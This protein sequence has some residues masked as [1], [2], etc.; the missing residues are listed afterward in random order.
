MSQVLHPRQISV[1]KIQI[2]S[3]RSFK[4]E[5]L[6]IVWHLVF[7]YLVLPYNVSLIRLLYPLYLGVSPSCSMI[8]DADRPYFS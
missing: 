1:A 6:N 3:F 7:R 4:A 8:L 5:S 2:F